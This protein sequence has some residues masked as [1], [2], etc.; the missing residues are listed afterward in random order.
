MKGSSPAFRGAIFFP[1]FWSIVKRRHLLIKNWCNLVR[2]ITAIVVNC[3]KIGVFFSKMT[4]VI[5]LYKLNSLIYSKLGPCIKIKI[6]SMRVSFLPIRPKSFLLFVIALIIGSNVIA[7]QRD[8][9]ISSMERNKLD[10]SITSITF[11]SLANWREDQALEIF[12]KYLGIDGID[13]TMVRDYSTTTKSMVTTQRYHQ[14]YKGIKAEYSTYTLTSKN[15][16]VT[17]ITGNYY[18]FSS[19]PS[20]VAAVTETVA[21]SKALQ[22]VGADKY[23]WQ[24]PIEEQRIK[25]MFHNPDTTFL[26]KG[27]LVW[28]DDYRTGTGYG[29]RHAHLAWSFDIY[30]Q[31]PL[32]RQTVF[33]DA[34]TGKILF[35]NSRIKH[36]AAS[37]HTR[38]SGVTAF[39]TA[40]HLG[41]YYL[42]DSSRGSGIHTLN[43]HNGSS[44]G[45]STEYTSL[46]NTWPLAVA[47]TVAL[48]AHWGAEVV[49]DYWKNVQG[50]LSYD[51]ADAI[52][53][54]YVHYQNNYNNAFWDGTEMT[55]GDGSG[56]STGFTPL[57]SLDVTGHEIG[58]G[59]CEYTANLVYA[60]ESGAMNESFSDC[61]GATIEAWGDPHEV[62][63]VPKQT[64]KIG[65]EIKCGTP[66]RSMDNPN[67]QGDPDTYAGTNWVNQV[68]C[69]P[70]GGNDQCGVH[71]NSGVMNHWYYLVCVGGA[72][73]N[74]IGNVFA[75]TGIGM[76]EGANILYQS[77]LALSS[78]AD[79]ALMRT[80]SINTAVTIY[81]PCSPEVVTVTNA[82]YAVGVGAAYVAYPAFIT[83]TTNICVGGTTTLLDATPGGTWTSGTPAVA[84]VAG[85]LVTGISAGTSVITYSVGTGCDAMV[86]VTV[87]AYPT[88]TISPAPAAILCTGSSVVLTAGSGVGYTYQ[89]KLATVNIPG[90]TNQVYTATLTGNYTVVETN[91]AGCSTTSAITVVNGVAPPPATI[92]PST[93]TTFCAGGSVV[94]NANAGA[95]FTYQ[96]QLAGVP[97]GGA[98][99]IAYT[100]SIGGNYS[101]IVTNSSGCST[102]S[103]NTLVT[104]NPLPNP[105]TGITSLCVTLTTT[106]NCTSPLGTWSSSNPAVATVGLGTG[107]V[108][109]ITAGT[110]TI[111]YTL[112]TGCYVSTPVTVNP[113]PMPITG[114]ASVCQGLTTTLFESIPGGIWS[115]GSPAIATVGTGGVV[116]GV[117][118]GVSTITYS[119]G[120]GCF[121]SADVTVNPLPS[122]ITGVLTVC[123]G[124]TT[125]LFDASPT[126][127]W[128][129][130]SPAVATVVPAT[131]VVTGVIAGTSDITYTLPTG[132]LTSATVTVNAPSAGAIAGSAS[133]CIGQTT[134]LTDGVPGGTWSS[135]NPALATI[136]SF[137][138]VT[139]VATGVVI[140][141]Y[142]VTTFCGTATATKSMTVNPLPAVA[143]I[144]GTLTQCSGRTSVLADATPSGVWTTSNN[145]IA[146]IGTTGIV[147]ALLPGLDTIS[148]TVTN[149]FGC[150][151]AATAVFT[152]TSAFVADVTPAGPTSFCTGGFVVLNATT[153]TGYTYQ[154]KKDGVNIAGA[155]TASYTANTSGGFNVIVTAPGGCNVTTS[156]IAVNVN[157]SPIVVPSVSISATPG[158]V[159]CVSV[160]PETLVAVPVNGGGAPTYQWFINGSSVSTS[161]SY[162]YTP[163]P[164]DIVKVIL[165]S[166]DACAFPLTATK[167]DT[168]TLSPLRSPAVSIVPTHSPICNG[169]TA[170]FAAIPIYGG[171]APTYL[172]TENGINVA[173]GP[174]Y[175]Y[176]PHYGDL[177][178][179]TM[180]SNYPCLTTN[181]AVSPTYT[182]HTQLPV[183]NSVTIFVTQSSIVTGSVDTFIAVATNGGTLPSY[184]WFINGVPVPGANSSTYITSTLTNGQ[185]V[186]CEETSNAPC[187]TPITARSGGIAVTVRSEAVSVKQVTGR[188]TNFNLLPNPNKGEFTIEGTLKNVTDGKVSIVITDMLGQVIYTESALAQNGVLS[189]HIKLDN[190]IANGVYLVSVTSGESHEVY[191]VVIDK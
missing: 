155:T 16:K 84:T 15:G 9:T 30:A 162:T 97:I 104:V 111:S 90:A 124:A 121:A 169:D 113:L 48:D 1:A 60:M 66:L 170:T 2:R 148:Y 119:L 149:G 62:D 35:S 184:Q 13:N 189:Q 28:M 63:A 188:E 40:F 8:N 179:C 47:D 105:I 109:G 38:Y 18:D 79:Y 86:T 29:D 92:T 85:G 4:S 144:S 116:S 23:M 173:T 176:A 11:S 43:M 145:I 57:T 102:T 143:A 51:N 131:G 61:W 24:D 20:T 80:T 25:N 64:W 103:A 171:S 112:G 89:W 164:G 139:G 93:S 53:L 186:T 174:Y 55:Y 95:G 153:G 5:I 68:G 39:E 54:Q 106:L 150:S 91:S 115:S 70:G 21:F 81:G 88:A 34:Q 136:N 108:T 122:A 127:T 14:F 181:V 165:T 180:T 183:T 71:T 178:I 59:V 154:W 33:V 156:S 58:H 135:S 187:V 152:V 132:C 175:I 46:A 117:T 137:G 26:P 172:W 75:V 100:A 110:A 50:R 44:Y 49:Y 6:I 114:S 146:T 69:V 129:S 3:S 74:D 101:V 56:C 163:T 168:I 17:F 76:L 98:T 42:Y 65:E 134:G 41:T 126:G 37:G 167:T 182:V 94:L 99:N 72:G 77:E 151:A 166:S 118:P 87:N 160:V 12:N 73:T 10:G 185:I 142:Q 120:A 190:N 125:S 19:N 78:T 22:F 130:G 107:I 67:L 36:T 27:H 96:W 32:S 157:P 7:Q 123:A 161:N 45:G 82:W 141:S 133:V 177:L 191:H 31:T 159:L 83:G 52:L 128:T 147:T 140:I 158:L 138:T